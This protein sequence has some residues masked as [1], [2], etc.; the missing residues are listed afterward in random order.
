MLCI[1]FSK[2]FPGATVCVII[3]GLGVKQPLQWKVLTSQG[4]DKFSEVV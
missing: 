1:A 4:R 2:M 3:E